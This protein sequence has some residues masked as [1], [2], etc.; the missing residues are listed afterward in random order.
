MISRKS[1]Y[2]EEWP[3]QSPHYI[4][5]VLGISH[6]VKSKIKDL[7]LSSHFGEKQPCKKSHKCN[8]FPLDG[9]AYFTFISVNLITCGKKKEI[10]IIV[11]DNRMTFQVQ[12]INCPVL[13]I[14]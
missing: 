4:F 10:G 1:D 9:L 6:F 13:M 2:F 8:V 11:N 7:M 14:N 12:H 3:W 5:I